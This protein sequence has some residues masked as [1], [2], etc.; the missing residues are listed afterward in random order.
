MISDYD[1]LKQMMIPFIYLAVTATVVDVFPNVECGGT[2][3]FIGHRRHV[4][5]FVP[6]V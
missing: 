6:V 4:V 3:L 1:G 2:V 5:Q